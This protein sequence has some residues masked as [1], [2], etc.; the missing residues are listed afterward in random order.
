MGKLKRTVL[1]MILASSILATSIVYADSIKI[2]AQENT[3]KD[4]TQTSEWKNGTKEERLA[5]CQIDAKKLSSMSTDELMQEVANCSFFVDILAYDSYQDGLEYFASEFNGMQELLNRKDL[6]DVAFEEYKNTEFEANFN[7]FT[8]NLLLQLVIGQEDV[9]SELA[10]NEPEEFNEV[11]YDNF[12]EQ[13]KVDYY[14][15]HEDV[16]Y[17][18]ASENLEEADHVDVDL[19]A[20]LNKDED[21]EVQAAS[22]TCYLH[23][24]NGT[25]ILA[26]NFTSDT[27]Y[28]SSE[29]AD[30][31]ES[32][33]AAYPN[34][35]YVGEATIKYNCHFYAWFFYGCPLSNSALRWVNDPLAF[36]T[37]GSATYKGKTPS[38]KSQKCIYYSSSSYSSATHSAVVVS[39]TSSTSYKLQS[40]WGQ[41]CLM[42]HS[43][44]DCPYT[45]S[46]LKF[47]TSSNGSLA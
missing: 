47:Y 26:Y 16:F 37:D 18:V 21:A 35:T 10:D 33:L 17:D 15:G 7:S 43:K 27:D 3:E 34:A 20:D 30:A 36:V 4:L 24:P 12:I 44:S 29:K 1:S 42:K 5:M 9:V 39:Y 13:T 25:A 41:L 40:K 14:R 19:F 28:S 46:Y 8:N 32:C 31:K 11:M 22:T 38:A 6:A 23:T 45:S 2:S